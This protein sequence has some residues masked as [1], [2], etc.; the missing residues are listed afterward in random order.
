MRYSEIKEAYLEEFSVQLD[1]CN[2]QELQEFFEAI[3]GS[4][5]SEQTDSIKDEIVSLLGQFDDISWL[6]KL[7]LFLRRKEV[8][9]LAMKVYNDTGLNDVFLRQ[10]VRMLIDSKQTYKKV[11][12]FL[13]KVYKGK[14]LDAEALFT[15]PLPKRVDEFILDQSDPVYQ[16]IREELLRWEGKEGVNIG[17]GE[18]FCIFLGKDVKKGTSGDLQYGKLQVEVKGDTARLKGTS[19]KF[20]GARANADKINEAIKAILPNTK[21][22]WTWI[23]VTNLKAL[24]EVMKHNGDPKETRRVLDLVATGPFPDIMSLSSYAPLVQNT[25]QSDGSFDPVKFRENLGRLNFEY[26]KDGE[27]DIL[28]VLSP[29]NFKT[30]AINN[31]EEFEQARNNRVLA[32]Q[33]KFGKGSMEVG[34]AISML[35]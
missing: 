8:H 15:N 14:M 1:R 10:F 32:V 7:M 27:F 23:T 9:E 5:L 21:F 20:E 25:I 24:A 2:E 35:K 12:Q 6:N 22:K 29:T 26:Y 16:S 30:I 19:G 17:K 18:F 13:R 4:R 3:G 33:P 28:L 31:G 11:E 34:Y